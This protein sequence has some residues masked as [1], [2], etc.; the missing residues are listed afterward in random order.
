[1]G[2]SF[3]TCSNNLTNN[4]KENIILK[5]DVSI[6]DNQ[7]NKVDI[8]YKNNQNDL[9]QKHIEKN[10]NFFSNINNDNLQN[11]ESKDKIKE[12]N[13]QEESKK[14]EEGEQNI[15]KENN[16]KESNNKENIIKIYFNIFL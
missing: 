13:S 12:N 5:S 8:I 4:N 3:C 1:M 9:A 7:P 2:I 10:T 14:S 6:S 15:D 16:N 11:Q